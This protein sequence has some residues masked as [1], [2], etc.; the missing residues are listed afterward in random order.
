MS[1]H[2]RNILLGLVVPVYILI[3]GQHQMLEFRKPLVCPA[4]DTEDQSLGRRQRLQPR[5]DFCLKQANILQENIIFV[6]E[7]SDTT[8]VKSSSKNFKMKLRKSV[9]LLPEIVE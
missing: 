5:R 6:K 9:D 2:C 4:P 3:N 7:T 1:I 8:S